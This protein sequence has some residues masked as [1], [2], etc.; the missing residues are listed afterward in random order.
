MSVRQRCSIDLCVCRVTGL[1]VFVSMW[2]ETWVCVYSVMCVCVDKLWCVCLGMSGEKEI[3]FF[4]CLWRV[5]CIL[6]VQERQVCV[7][8]ETSI[9]VAL[10][11]YVCVRVHVCVCVCVNGEKRGVRRE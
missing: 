7:C 3:H 8:V 11:M 5:E 10:K 6:E 1:C 9:D 4:I 2:G